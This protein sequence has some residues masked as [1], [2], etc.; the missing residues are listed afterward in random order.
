MNVDLMRFIDRKV[1]IPLCFL[2]SCLDKVSS[3]FSFGKKRR[4]AVK[5]ILFM[6]ISEMG[7]AISAYSSILKAKELYPDAEIY[8]FIF[9][10]M[11][12]S[13]HL[14]DIIPKE[15]VLTIPSKSLTG[16]IF[17][18]IRITLVMRRLKFDVILDLELFSRISAILS[19]LF[20]ARIK[21]GFY[22]F[23]MEGL[24][25]GSYHSHK[26]LYNHLRHISH[27]FLSLVY[28]ISHDG[29]ENPVTK[30]IIPAS[31]IHIKK[32]V[33]S[34]ERKKAILDLLKRKHPGI[35]SNSTLIVFNPNASELLPLRRWPLENYIQLAKNILTNKNVFII[36]TGVISEIKDADAICFAVKNERC[37]SIA[38]ETSL[39][40]LIDLYNI[41]DL[42]LSNDSGPPN[43]ASLTDIKVLVFFG[44]ESP[45]CY[46]PLGNNVEA[47]YAD[48]ICS[49]CVSAYNHRKSGCHNNRCLQSISPDYVYERI[50]KNVKF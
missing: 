10:E 23:Y 1:G 40:G 12:A 28:A 2:L 4:S 11:Q 18:V 27:N 3:I 29:K 46:K 6:Q 21:V 39:N 17:G 48:F 25:R 9:S 36:V 26:V 44:P 47:L 41:S 43:F 37:I 50:K 31:D 38:G 16:L 45:I 14:L 24:Y 33:S 49:P 8:Y 13:V 22:R 35:K 7:S 19:Y 34:P 42:L 15:R 5:K 20:G 32:V 30:M